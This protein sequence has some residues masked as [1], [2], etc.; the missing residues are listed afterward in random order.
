MATE[1]ES[2]DIV[3]YP[4]EF[5]ERYAEELGDLTIA[6]EFRKTA[7]A[8]PDNVALI[9]P[10]EELTYA[11]LDR[12]SDRVT[13]GLRDLGLEPGERVLMQFTNSGW[14]VIAWYGLIKAGAVPVATLAQHREHE[15]FD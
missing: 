9:T 8:H 11:E 15:I 5:K 3:P 10:D 14:A 2:L 6:Q 4:P 1:T 13:L 12:R 7:D